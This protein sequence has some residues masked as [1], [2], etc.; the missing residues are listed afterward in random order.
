[1]VFEFISSKTAFLE[2]VPFFNSI[3]IH[4]NTHV[5][6]QIYIY[7]YMNIYIFMY[8]TRSVDSCNYA[9]SLNRSH[10]TLCTNWCVQTCACVCMRMCACMFRLLLVGLEDLERHAL[11]PSDLLKEILQKGEERCRS[12]ICQGCVCVFE[13]VCVCCREESERTEV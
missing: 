5:Y 9:P 12:E 6:K 7:I 4:K 13:C 3:Y 8:D 1:M 11:G 2:L 10:T